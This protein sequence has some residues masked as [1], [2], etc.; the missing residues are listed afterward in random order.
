MRLAVGT[1]L[2]P[3]EIQSPIGEGGMGE[4]YTARD[5][6]LDRTVAIKVL[7]ARAARDPDRRRRF[8]QEARAVAALNHPH[9][10]TLYD[11]GCAVASDPAAPSPAATPPQTASP[12]EPIHF[13]VMEFL[14]GRTLK[15]ELE[16]APE[17]GGGAGP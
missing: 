8:E 13:L 16:Q 15:Q 1:R 14:E 3:Y 6:R 9:I 7:S 10:C 17:A 11:V 4:V 12:S 2:G 5:V